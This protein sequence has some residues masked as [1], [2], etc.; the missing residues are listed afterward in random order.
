M[1]IGVLAHWLYQEAKQTFLLTGKNFATWSK[2]STEV[3]FLL[4][5]R[6]WETGVLSHLTFT[7]QKDGSQS[8]KKTFQGQQKDYLVFK[9]IRGVEEST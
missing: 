7:F 6:N 5:H 3:R 2:V 9:R 1:V 8:L 4:S